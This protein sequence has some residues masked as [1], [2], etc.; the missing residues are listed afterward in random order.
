MPARKRHSYSVFVDYPDEERAEILYIGASEREAAFRFYRAA[1]LSEGKV[2]V[3]MKRD[4]EPW[5]RVAV[6]R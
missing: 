4:G 2:T 6:L 3:I 5:L 1:R